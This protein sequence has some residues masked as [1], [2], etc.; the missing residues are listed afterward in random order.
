[1]G[2][3]LMF[4]IVPWL[5][6]SRQIPEW[7]GAAKLLAQRHGGLTPARRRREELVEALVEDRLVALQLDR[8][9]KSMKKT[10]VL[11]SQLMKTSAVVEP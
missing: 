5:K 11:R 10:M 9:L 8:F 3:V 6:E 1:M 2:T 7:I 4:G